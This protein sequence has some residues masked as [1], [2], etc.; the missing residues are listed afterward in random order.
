MIDNIN[1]Q[2]RKG[3]L[4]YCVLLTLQH[5]R[6]YPSDILAILK[7]ANMIVVEGTLYTLL[8]R[9]KR[10]GKLDYSWEESP[11]GPPRKYYRLTEQGERLLNIMG[12][13]WDSLSNT[14]DSLRVLQ[15]Q[16]K[17]PCADAETESETI[18]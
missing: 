16:K 12:E 8:N 9:M 4:E 15:K 18:K 11:K 13:S 1:T 2:M 14:I 10:E 17:L 7:E 6:A 5:D 3:M